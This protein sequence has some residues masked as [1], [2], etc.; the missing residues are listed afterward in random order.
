MKIAFLIMLLFG[1]YLMML[2]LGA[3]L[4]REVF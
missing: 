1:L 4:A 2:A 3:A